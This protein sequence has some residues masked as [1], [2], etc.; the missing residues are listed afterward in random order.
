MNYQLTGREGRRGREER[1]E[2]LRRAA[3]E[4]LRR[5]ESEGKTRERA[6]LRRGGNCGDG[7][8]YPGSGQTLIGFLLPK[9]GTHDQ[10][11]V[12]SFLGYRIAGHDDA[13]DVGNRKP[14]VS[15]TAYRR[16]K[17]CQ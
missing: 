15:Q 4:R 1:R 6:K 12:L 11:F 13:H 8:I 3:V 5:R 14:R 17:G 16:R 10:I 7:K 2:E 9:L